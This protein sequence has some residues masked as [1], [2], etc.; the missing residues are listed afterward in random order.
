MTSKPY[1]VGVTGPRGFI[2]GGLINRLRHDDRFELVDWPRSV[3]ESMAELEQRTKQCD[4]IV[5][6]AGMNRGDDDEIYQTNVALA[7]RLS[8]ACRNSD[9]KPHI[10]NVSS[11]QRE[12]ENAYGKSKRHAEELLNEWA[13]ESEAPVTSLILPNIYGAGCK[14]YYNSVVAT[15]CHKLA[16][17]ERPEVK[18][19]R[20]VE[21]LWINDLV[22]EIVGYI[23][24]PT[25]ARKTLRLK[26]VDRITV[27]GL[28][29]TLTGFRDDYFERN[30]VPELGDRFRANLYST[31]LSYLELDQHRHCPPLHQD[32]RGDLCEII[33]LAGGGQ[34]FFSTTKPGVIRGNHYHTRKVEWFCVVKGEGAI[35]LRRI[36]DDQ[37]REFRVS[38]AKPEFISI[39]VLHTHSI[40]NV[41]SEELLTMFWCNEIFD[42]EDADT[43]FEKVA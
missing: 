2:A 27:Q 43:H 40:E 9:A 6:L 32:D 7:E 22:D 28:C 4:V 31:F 10:I 16:N 35:R 30:V 36:G 24:D 18:E 5:H 17:G 38:G 39:P 13:E 26:G 8:T 14:P 20:E 19:D 37:V 3:W 34:V 33:K 15:F 23:T 29:D 12:A 42:A 41:G 11:T 21:F 25:P 1:K